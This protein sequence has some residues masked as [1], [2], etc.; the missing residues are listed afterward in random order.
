MD[1]VLSFDGGEEI[2]KFQR[3][4]I[5]PDA[6][7]V[8][9]DFRSVAIDPE[10]VD[11]ELLTAIVINNVVEISVFDEESASVVRTHKI[12]MEGDLDVLPLA[13]QPP[14]VRIVVP[15]K[16]LI[17]NDAIGAKN[18]RQIEGNVALVGEE[19]TKEAWAETTGVSVH[20]LA[21]AEDYFI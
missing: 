4:D 20:P 11:N 21:A 5:L 16:A 12:I 19:S 6:M 7:E 10:T 17:P 15:N 8:R 1:V 3:R 14:S 2:G 9:V 13:F 18:R